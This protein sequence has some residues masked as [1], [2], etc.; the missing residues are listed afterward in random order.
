M[1]EKSSKKQNILGGAM[2][3]VIATA[4]VKVIGAVYKIPLQNIMGTLANGYYA[5][6]YSIYVPVYAISMAGL[7]VAISAIVSKNV[8][9]GKYRDVKQVMKLTFPLFL[10]LG[11]LGTG[12]LLLAAKP[13]VSIVEN[14]NALLSVIAI[15]P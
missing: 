13:Y 11:V 3:L 7:P 12:V 2:V 5:S 14:P 6:A 10:G 1:A 9:L 8:A 4:L 15:A